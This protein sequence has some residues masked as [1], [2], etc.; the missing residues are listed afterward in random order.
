MEILTNKLPCIF[1]LP[2]QIDLFILHPTLLSQSLTYN[3]YSSYTEILHLLVPSCVQPMRN[4]GDVEKE[5]DQ[6]VYI[7]LVP[8]LI[9]SERQ[10]SF[11]QSH[12]FLQSGLFHLFLQFQIPITTPFTH[13]WGGKSS[14]FFKISVLSFLFYLYNSFINKPFSKQSNLSKAFVSY[15]D[16]D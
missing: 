10:L 12:S 9:H 4:P 15:F 2:L 11:L 14:K 16:P 5:G 8:S 7:P 1:C 6:A 13:P 3:H